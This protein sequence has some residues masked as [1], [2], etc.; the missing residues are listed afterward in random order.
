V[1][2]QGGHTHAKHRNYD[3]YQYPSVNQVPALPPAITLATS[4]FTNAA[5]PN[6]KNAVRPTIIASCTIAADMNLLAH[7]SELVAFLILRIL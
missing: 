3:V 2:E 4:S 7:T 5:C 6:T 1:V